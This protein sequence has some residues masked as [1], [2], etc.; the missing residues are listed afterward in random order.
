MLVL[1]H[2][3]P[4]PV[5]GSALRVENLR[6]VAVVKDTFSI[7]VRHVF[8]RFPALIPRV[9]RRGRLNFT[10]DLISLTE[11]EAL[12]LVRHDGELGFR[13][14]ES[15]SDSPGH[16]A[17][18][19]KL[20]KQKGYLALYGLKSLSDAA[21]EALAQHEGTLNL[22]GLTSLS[23][24]AVAALAKHEGYLSLCRLTSLSDAAAE[25][26]VKHEGELAIEGEPKK[27]VELARERLTSKKTQK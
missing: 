17:L 14:L 24:A 20:A 8:I 16:M 4:D 15:L 6:S 2:C 18:A 3:P 22:D 13:S 12:T 19:E 11:G 26:L 21:A 10:E 5:S 9:A 27:A 1:S 23:D 25:A 7:L